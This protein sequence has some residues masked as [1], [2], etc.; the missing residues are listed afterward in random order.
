[1]VYLTGTTANTT[2]FYGILPREDVTITAWTDE[3][4]TDLLAKFGISGVTLLATDPALI[5]PAGKVNGSL[6]LGATGSVWL[7][8][9]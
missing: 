6:T 5:I 2:S 3:D 1:M 9:E 4:G 7:L 8:K